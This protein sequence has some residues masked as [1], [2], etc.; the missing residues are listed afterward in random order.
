M[1]KSV[2]NT[3]Y[4]PHTEL[5]AGDKTSTDF[6]A[7]RGTGGFPGGAGGKEPAC[8]CR[9]RRTLGFSPWVEKIPRRREGMAAHS[10][11]LA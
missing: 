5:R 6:P 10:S 2:M 1:N 3:Y 7:L 4:A 11:I 8:Q 9:R